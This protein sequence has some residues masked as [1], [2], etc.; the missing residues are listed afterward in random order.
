MVVV[1]KW[2]GIAFDDPALSKA[3]FLP[4]DSWNENGNRFTFHDEAGEDYQ[5]PVGK[6]FIAGVLS[7]GLLS[8]VS[9]NVALIG[10]SDAA[11]AALTKTLLTMGAEVEN[12]FYYR[13]VFAIFTAGKYVTGHS[14]GAVGGHALLTNSAL[15]GVE[16]P[17]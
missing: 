11:D 16:A 9:A 17:A 3:L 7:F 14:K 4:A 2:G 6:V 5:V 15:Y 13:K 1:Y 10:E 12:S 8:L